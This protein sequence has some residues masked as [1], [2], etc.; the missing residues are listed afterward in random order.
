MTRLVGKIVLAWNSEKG[1]L[2]SRLIRFE[3]SFL[4]IIVAAHSLVFLVFL[5]SD[6]SLQ[7]KVAVKPYFSTDC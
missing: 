1:L 7:I 6:E 3:H 4:L 2:V 5:S